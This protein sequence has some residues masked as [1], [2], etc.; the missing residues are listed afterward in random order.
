LC[1]VDQVAIEGVIIPVKLGLSDDAADTQ[2][3]RTTIAPFVQP[4]P[5]NKFRTGHHQAWAR[6]SVL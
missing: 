5:P 3:E 4:A 1:S 2:T 6:A